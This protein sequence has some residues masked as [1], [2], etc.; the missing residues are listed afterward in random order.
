M[1]W[2]CLELC[3]TH[4]LHNQFSLAVNY[5]GFLQQLTASGFQIPWQLTA[6]EYLGNLLVILSQTTCGNSNSH[7]GKVYKTSK[8]QIATFSASDAIIKLEIPLSRADCKPHRA[9]KAST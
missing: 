1:A 3:R 9:P 6:E 7:K 8:M 4:C 2:K 5:R